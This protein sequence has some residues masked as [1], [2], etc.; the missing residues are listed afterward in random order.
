MRSSVIADASARVVETLRAL[1]LAR[2]DA[3]GA[4]EAACAAAFARAGARGART[5][6][7]GVIARDAH[8]LV[9]PI[10]ARADDADAVIGLYVGDAIDGLRVARVGSGGFF[11]RDRS[12]GE[13]DG[14]AR[15]RVT[16]SGRRGATRLASTAKTY[17][18]RVLAEID[19]DG[20]NDDAG[21][22]ALREIVGEEYYV[23]GELA[24]SGLASRF[25]VFATK[26]IERF[27]DADEA[28]IEA[29][30]KRNDEISALVTAEWHAGGPYEG[31]ARPHAINART[32]ARYGRSIEARDQARVALSAGPWW[33]IDEDGELMREMQRLSGFAGRSA[34][35]ARRTL[36]GGD[37]DA[38][39]APMEEGGQPPT[40]EEL[41]IRRAT[42]A[43]EAVSWG[44]CGDKGWASVRE[45]VAEAYAEAGLQ[46]LS[47]YVLAPLR[48]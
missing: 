44:E 43:M 32:L 26:R 38:S 2:G 37:I 40:K 13:A 48:Q 15:M 11:A 8:P 6:V 9:I 3:T 19:R 16:R 10:A 7:D 25:E 41:A 24:K 31:W 17:A 22:R 4:I 28:L 39:G 20:L 47:E 18:R 14:E 23:A 36:D 35:D 46:N 34:V 30:V 33:T 1:G 12:V 45:V 42:A 21:V 5:A 29:H 27:M